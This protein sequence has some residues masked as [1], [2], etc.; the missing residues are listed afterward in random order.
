[1]IHEQPKR[2]GIETLSR[3]L[4]VTAAKL[5]QWRDAFLAGDAEVSKIALQPRRLNTSASM[6]KSASRPWRSNCFASIIDSWRQRTLWVT[7]VEEMSQSTSP[8]A[9]QKYGL[10]RVCQVLGIP[11]STNYAHKA[12]AVSAPVRRGPVG[13]HSDDELL[14]R[15]AA[16]IHSSPL[17]GEG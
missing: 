16:C 8:S 15:L 1:M 12:S 3:E 11:R 13:Y 6:R 7:E 9:G 5:S 14:D 4:G 17:T 2:Q 10:V